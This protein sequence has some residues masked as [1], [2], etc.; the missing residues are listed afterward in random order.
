MFSTILAV[1]LCNAMLT[2]CKEYHPQTWLALSEKEM[3]AEEMQC[4][5]AK[6]FHE[7]QEGYLKSACFIITEG[8]NSK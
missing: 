8:S 5:A 2:E 1:V 3:M 6:E 7:Q 4:E